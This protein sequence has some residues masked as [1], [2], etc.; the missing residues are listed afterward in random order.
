MQDYDK[1]YADLFT[2]CKTEHDDVYNPVDIMPFVPDLTD[3]PPLTSNTSC[4]RIK[5]TKLKD[6][7]VCICPM[8][9]HGVADAL[10]MNMFMNCWSKAYNREEFDVPVFSPGDVDR[11]AEP[12]ATRTLPHKTLN[13]YDLWA[14][15]DAAP[16]PLQ[17][18]CSGPDELIAKEPLGTPNQFSMGKVFKIYF[19]KE[20]IENMNNHVAQSGVH[21]SKMISFLAHLYTAISNA[22]PEFDE[23][24]L[25]LILGLRDRLFNNG[26]N[27]DNHSGSFVTAATLT[28]DVNTSIVENARK[29]NEMVDSY[30]CKDVLLNELNAHAT[31][32]CPTR[33]FPVNFAPQ[34]V[35]FT[36]WKGGKT[37][38]LKFGKFLSFERFITPLGEYNVV[39]A[40]GNGHDKWYL[41][42]AYAYINTYPE[43]WEKLLASPELK[44]WRNAFSN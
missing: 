26:I 17:P 10:A 9:S 32:V 4:F 11:L 40:K 34:S 13:L 30:K 15:K 16:P 42:G 35:T 38:N 18:Y 33:Y 2:N 5:I 27:F 19:S 12:T 23:T 28:S 6:A 21:C 20:E 36:T 31:T 29:I 41:E 37:T 1:T 39:T 43:A 14:S 24:Q 8:T 3:M 22:K 7:S 44:R 25:F